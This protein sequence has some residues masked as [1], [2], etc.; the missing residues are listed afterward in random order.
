MTLEFLLP[1]ETVS[2]NIIDDS[3]IKDLEVVE[4]KKQVKTQART[5]CL[6]LST[7]QNILWMNLLRSVLCLHIP[8]TFRSLHKPLSL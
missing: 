5:R 7:N 6:M 2:H 4:S 8:L 3:V 1:I